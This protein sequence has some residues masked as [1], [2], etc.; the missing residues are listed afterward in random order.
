MVVVGYDDRVEYSTDDGD[1]FTGTTAGTA[2]MHLSS[3]AMVDSH[4]AV[5][6]AADRRRLRM[7]VDPTAAATVSDWTATTNDWDS[8]D[9]FGVCLQ[10]IGGIAVADWI[11]DSFN[12]VNQCE[13]LDSDPWQAVPATASIAAHTAAAGN[14]SIDLVW[15]LRPRS[16]QQQGTYEAGVSFEAVAP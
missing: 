10:E 12:A 5:I 13:M 9:F 4:T 15:G 3:I 7:D 1:T 16:D 14:G 2:G 11:E 6:G 8:G